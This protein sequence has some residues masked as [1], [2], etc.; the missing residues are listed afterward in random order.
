[1]AHPRFAHRRAHERLCIS[2]SEPMESSLEVQL[3]HVDNITAKIDPIRGL[4]SMGPHSRIVASGEQRL[5]M[6][7]K[8][9]AEE[10]INM[11]DCIR[12]RFAVDELQRRGK[13]CGWIRTQNAI[14]L[15]DVRPIINS[16]ENLQIVWFK[17]PDW[18]SK[19]QVMANLSLSGDR[20]WLVEL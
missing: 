12:C 4:F 13:S 20:W 5:N 2:A 15:E 7:G 9:P 18:D 1:M 16:R 17:R 14:K 3:T 10:G 19:W 11:L 6:S 8:D